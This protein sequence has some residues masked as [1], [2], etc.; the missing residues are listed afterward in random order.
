MAMRTDALLTLTQWFS[1]G[2]PLGAFSYSH[3]LEYAAHA[4]DVTDAASLHAWLADVLDHGAG[5]SDALFLAAGFHAK[6]T[7]ALQQINDTCRAFAASA[8]RLRETE[9]QGAAFCKITSDVW[10]ADLDGLTYPVAVGRAAHLCDLPLIPTATLYL[11]GF[12]ANLV[13]A[14]QRLAPIGQSAAQK[15]L[16]DLAPL[17]QNIAEETQSGDLATL[18]VTAFL[19]DIASM[20]HE[21]QR[22]RIFQT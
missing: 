1:P 8:E 20:R 4:G 16:R 21:T 9:L 22:S 18:S 13:A 11:Q 14:G 7:S 5:R 6:D 10:Q 19:A 3:G 17:C 15:V 2:Y 12:A